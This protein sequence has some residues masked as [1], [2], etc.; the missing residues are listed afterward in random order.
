M[1]NTPVVSKSCSSLR[2]SCGR[3]RQGSRLPRAVGRAS[4]FCGT[5]DPRGLR[6]RPRQGRAGERWARVRFAGRGRGSPAL[7]AA[8]LPV[9]EGRVRISS[10]AALRLLASSMADV[11]D[12][13]CGRRP[14]PATAGHPR[15]RPATAR[16]RTRTSVLNLDGATANP[17]VCAWFVATSLQFHCD[18]R[19]SVLEIRPAMELRALVPVRVDSPVY[20]K[21]CASGITG[22]RDT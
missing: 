13:C 6:P 21:F 5:S 22:T 15:P 10:A 4:A 11:R 3:V 9:V 8:G 2:R 7:A 1:V 18:E 17:S 14:R 19:S 12:G 20:W 16:Q